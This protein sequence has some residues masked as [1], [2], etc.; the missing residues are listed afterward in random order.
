[1]LVGWTLYAD[2]RPPFIG[3]CGNHTATRCGAPRSNRKS[4]FITEAPLAQAG[5][6]VLLETAGALE[7][8]RRTET[9]RRTPLQAFSLPAACRPLKHQFAEALRTSSRRNNP[10]AALHYDLE[11]HGVK[12]LYSDYVVEVDEVRTV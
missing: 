6:H 4:T 2:R 9:R 12:W 3:L 1:M 10:G 7:L 11:A 8:E 5:G